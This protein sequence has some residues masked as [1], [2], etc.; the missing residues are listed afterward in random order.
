[1]RSAFTNMNSPI[2]KNVRLCALRYGIGEGDFVVGGLVR[3][4][5]V[6]FIYGLPRE[7]F[8]GSKSAC[9]AI[10]LH[11][12]LLWR[13]NLHYRS[14]N[15]LPLLTILLVFDVNDVARLISIFIISLILFFIHAAVHVCTN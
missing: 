15:L 11:E 2:G 8:A 5:L 12:G 1:V 13:T 4:F 3:T 10:A 9:E 7:V 6:S 14:K